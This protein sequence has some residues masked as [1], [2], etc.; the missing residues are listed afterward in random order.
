[1]VRLPRTTGVLSGLLVVLLGTWAGFIAFV[2]PYFDFGFTPDQAWHYSSSRLWLCILPA[3]VVVLGGLM[4]IFANRRSTGALGGWLAIAGGAWLI[5]GPS[6]SLLWQTNV[7]IGSPLGG[8]HRQA[9]EWVGYFY[10]VGAL[11]VGFAAF[12]TGRFW[13]RPHLA[14]QAALEHPEE[15]RAAAA[16]TATE[17]RRQAEP[18]P[19]AQ[20]ESATAAGAAAPAATERRRPVEPHPGARQSETTPDDAPSL[21]ESAR[22]TEPKPADGGSAADPPRA[23]PERVEREQPAQRTQAPPGRIRR[24]RGGLLGRLLGRRSPSE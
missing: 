12:A 5:V 4:M 18:Q 7:G 11:I 21:T 19:A 8:G 24:R 10:G 14:E 17:R 3:A 22:G 15:R 20:Q 23:E 16:T 2:G 9:I 1:M 6:L 13:S